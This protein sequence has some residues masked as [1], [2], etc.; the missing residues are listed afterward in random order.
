MRQRWSGWLRW[1]VLFSLWIVGAWT[2]NAS[3]KKGVGLADLKAGERLAALHVAWYYTWKPYPIEGVSKE[4]F[5]PMIWGGRQLDKQMAALRARGKVPVLLAINEPNKPD[6]ANMSVAETVRRWPEIE[7][8]A[9]R[10]S[11]P[12]PAGVLGRWFQKFHRLAQDRG[13]RFDFLAVHLY[14]PPD[15]RKFLTKIDAIHEKY[16]MPIWITEFAVADWRAK[17]KGSNRYSEAKVLEF[18]QQVLPELEKRPYIERYAWFGAGQR[19]LTREP[20]YTSR[21][22]EKDG[23]LTALGRFYAHF[24][25]ER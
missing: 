1:V 2:A 20:V 13:L 6:Q 5:V 3:G 7:A 11:S 12:A 17:R 10:I 18:M 25:A 24:Q 15:P 22:F 4:E 23:A 19:S 16:D 21:L 9:D 8:L 14:G